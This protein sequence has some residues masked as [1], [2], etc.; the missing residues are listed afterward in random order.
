MKRTLTLS[1]CVAALVVG[2]SGSA[3][4]QT[5]LQPDAAPPGAGVVVSLIAANGG[6]SGSEII[7]TSCPSEI[8]VGPTWLSDGAG[9]TSAPIANA[10]LST[11]FFIL[12]NAPPQDCTVSIDGTPL[13]ATG[14]I[15]N[16]FSIVLPRPSPVDGGVGDLDGT[17]DGRITVASTDRSDGGVVVF[18]TLNIPAGKTMVFD[19]TDPVPATGG[20][21]ALMPIIVLVRGDAVIDGAVDA[22]GDD[23]K[24]WGDNIL[25]RSHAAESGIDGGDGGHG[26]PGG[27]GGAAGGPHNSTAGG[28]TGGFSGT[29][30]DGFAGGSG[31]PSIVYEQAPGGAGVAYPPVGVT[32]GNSPFNRGGGFPTSNVTNGGG[33]GSGNPFG[34]GAYG[35][36]NG[37]NGGAAGY[38]GGGGAATG[39]GTY[40][41]GGGGGFATAGT[42]G[43]LGQAC[44]GRGGYVNGLP[45]LLPLM[46]GS[47][48]GGGDGWITSSG[49][50]FS[51]QYG[52]GGGGGGGG[53]FAFVVYGTLSGSG[54]LLADGGDGGAAGYGNNAASGGGGGSGG[55]ISLAS[56]DLAF[57]GT[58]SVHGGTGGDNASY[59]NGHNL[60]GKGGEG[61]V[62]Y[63]GAAPPTLTAGPTGTVG[64]TWQ[65]CAV[66]GVDGAIVHVVTAVTCDYTAIDIN[67][68]VVATGTAG[69][70]DLDLSTVSTAHGVLTVVLSRQGVPSP[71]G[72]GRV[73]TDSD[74]DGIPD[75]AD[76][77]DD[78]DCISDKDELG[79]V[80]LT[81][82][83]D[84]DNVPDYQDPDYVSCV[85]GDSN[86]ICD[87]LP[88][89]LD[90]DGDGIVNSLDRDSD[91]DGI[92]DSVEACGTLVDGDGDG[93][94]DDETD[95]D[96]DG[97]S[98]A[99]DEDD[100]DPQ[101]S[102]TQTPP[103]E[104]DTDGTADFLDTDSDG[105][106]IYDLTE[107]G[108]GALDGDGDGKVD[109]VTDVDGD[110]IPDAVDP[111]NDETGA[112]LND[113]IQPPDSDGD[114]VPDYQAPGLPL[115]GVLRL[116]DDSLAGIRCYYD[117]S[118]GEAGTVSCETDQS[119][120][121]VLYPPVCSP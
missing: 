84:A 102:G 105:D 120:A 9:N 15:D 54:Q 72:I 68:N 1:L 40:S 42:P 32:G 87:A 2:L 108:G 46:G 12:E 17:V 69:A 16:V 95:G 121:L 11:V 104:S 62:R 5:I 116:A 14:A 41:G 4:A 6:F 89:A 77:D 73:V 80:D 99:V 110:G 24:D 22:S 36:P 44:G 97:V 52:G 67:G 7:T 63:D 85:D 103:T 86:G 13:A 55:G 83:Q 107:A 56:R 37:T 111:T 101:Q 8:I 91:G 115:F 119:G 61:R 76:G 106:G 74:G 47:G 75:F 31:S 81:G 93:S 90:A 19:R 39:N 70:G 98:G 71:V 78:N 114:G 50:N 94:V 20:N 34:T 117:A 49:S 59:P 113:P 112:P 58:V 60:G 25:A 48:G 82:D 43:G 96:F 92:P 18:S 38:G 57:T 79:G 118:V 88:P 30:G 66:S 27:G 21:E 35:A 109:D 45:S 26:G 3:A 64:S 28:G 33:G 53:A 65:G 51:G 23:G 10:V 100:G 29:G